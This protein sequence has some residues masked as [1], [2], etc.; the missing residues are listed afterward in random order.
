[1][2]NLSQ[3]IKKAQKETKNMEELI[4]KFSPLIRHFASRLPYDRQDATQDMVLSFL[5][6][7]HA[8]QL[9]ELYEQ[10]DLVLLAK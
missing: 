9:D 4:N 1:M 7:I 10:N 8:I 6:I 5:Q 3:L 2:E